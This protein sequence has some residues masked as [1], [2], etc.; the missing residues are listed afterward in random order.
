[1]PREGFIDGKQDLIDYSNWIYEQTNDWRN[2]NAGEFREELS[3]FEIDEALDDAR[4]LMDNIMEEYSAQGS[5]EDVHSVIPSSSMADPFQRFWLVLKKT[6]KILTDG[7]C[8]QNQTK[9]FG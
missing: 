8:G 3:E 5:P 6:N 1:M 9:I 4:A 2:A 7:K